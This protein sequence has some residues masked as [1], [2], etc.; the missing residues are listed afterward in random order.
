[1]FLLNGDGLNQYANLE[2]TLVLFSGPDK[3]FLL[4]GDG[5]NQ[6]ANLEKISVLQEAGYFFLLGGEDQ[7][8]HYIIINVGKKRPQRELEYVIR[9]SKY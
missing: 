4:N 8:N 2:K 3:F 6:Y 9:F 5:L 7:R 1:M